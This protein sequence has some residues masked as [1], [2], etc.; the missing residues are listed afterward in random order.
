M[1]KKTLTYEDWNGNTVTEDF[2]F[3][4]TK[5]EVLELEYGLIPGKSLTEVINQL[6]SDQDMG[7]II[8]T[9]KE[10]LLK[11]YGQKTEDGKRFIKN[12]E[13]QDSF[14]Q[15]PAFDIIYMELATSEDAAADFISGL[16]PNDVK[17]QLGPDPKQALLDKMKEKQAEL[18]IV[19]S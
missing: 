6:S 8:Q 11:A 1:L 19:E 3:N 16:L 18:S 12:Q 13:I 2:Y 15:S 10:I 7:R 5:T 17:T 9:L 4:L 14:L